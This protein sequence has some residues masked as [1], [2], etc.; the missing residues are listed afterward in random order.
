MSDQ[1]QVLVRNCNPARKKVFCSLGAIPFG[2]EKLVSREDL[3]KLKQFVV[4]VPS[5]PR[6]SPR[7]PKRV[8]EGPVDEDN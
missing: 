5:S 6:R 4:E 2:A 3:E 7:R 1:G 8:I